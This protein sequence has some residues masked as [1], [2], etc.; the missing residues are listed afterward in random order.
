MQSTDVYYGRRKGEKKKDRGVKEEGRRG[1]EREK[2]R[3]KGRGE[4]GKSQG[5]KGTGTANL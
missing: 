3:G 5:K 2:K 4:E 1:R